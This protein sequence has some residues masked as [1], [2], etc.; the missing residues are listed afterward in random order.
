MKIKIN[1]RLNE[2]FRKVSSIVIKEGISTVCEEALCPNIF[3]CW[4]DK[5]ATFMIMGNICTRGCRFCY[6]TKG[7]P[8]NLDPSE[9][10]RVA[11]AVRAM[12]LDYVVIT[13]VDR[14]DLKDGGASHFADVVKKVKEVN[15]AY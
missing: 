5:T 14:D 6:V 3:E 4:G 7:K 13:S 10:L 9:P 1:A 2:N 11:N 12:E 8:V 15:Q